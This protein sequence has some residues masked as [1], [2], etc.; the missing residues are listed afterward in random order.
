MGSQ[1]AYDAIQAATAEAVT[2]QG[3]TG[4]FETVVH[5]GGVDIVVRGAVVD[6]ITRIST[7]FI[8]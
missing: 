1:A 5:V 8:P 3:L 7:A 4:V 2:G 6:G